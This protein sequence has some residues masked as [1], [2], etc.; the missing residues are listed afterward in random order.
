M[1]PRIRAQYHDLGQAREA[2]LSEADIVTQMMAHLKARLQALHDKNWSGQ[3]SDAFFREMEEVVLPGMKRLST[4]LDQSGQVIGAISRIFEDADQDVVALFKNGSIEPLAGD[5]P[6]STGK[7]EVIDIGIYTNGVDGWSIISNDGSKG[8]STNELV[9]QIG[10]TCSLYSA[11]NLMIE[12]GYDISQINADTF[13]SIREIQETNWFRTLL[14]RET[15]GFPTSV[16]ENVLTS[17]GV[18]YQKGDFKEANPSG[19]FWGPSKVPNAAKAEQFLI[20]SVK[21]GK[22]VLATMYM[23]ESFGTSGAHALTVVGVKTGPDGKLQSVLAATNWENHQVQ[24]I[25]AKSFM[26]DWLKYKGGEYITIDRAPA[27][28]TESGPNFSR[29]LLKELQNK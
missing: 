6:Y 27:P 17:H 3:G 12:N 24:E 26:D 16:A 21:S 19:G 14:N 5:N 13:V 4:S 8:F 29:D 7:G 28:K 15:K 22:P 9:S 11:L 18:N 20:N 23:S 2:M 1:A 10:N 25:P